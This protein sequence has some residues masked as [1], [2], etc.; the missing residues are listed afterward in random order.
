MGEKTV[1]KK[2]YV[3]GYKEKQDV[4]YKRYNEQDRPGQA[5]QLKIV[6][7]ASKRVRNKCGG[8]AFL[9]SHRNGIAS[10]ELFSGRV[11]V[12]WLIKVVVIAEQITRTI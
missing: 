10:K 8:K 1:S 11:E 7:F 3:Y 2:T 4:I 5:I 6:L 12:E 9:L